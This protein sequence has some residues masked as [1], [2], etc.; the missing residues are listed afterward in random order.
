MA[1]DCG[2]HQIIEKEFYY[3]KTSFTNICGDIDRRGNDHKQFYADG[4]RG[5]DR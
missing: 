3:V 2:F 5:A 4:K 1:I